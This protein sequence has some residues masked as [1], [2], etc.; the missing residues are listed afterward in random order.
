MIFTKIMN[1]LYPEVEIENKDITGKYSFEFQ[2]KYHVYFINGEDDGKIREQTRKVLDN[3][4]Y[5][6][7]L[8]DDTELSMDGNTNVLLTTGINIKVKD[9]KETDEISD[10]WIKKYKASLCI[11]NYK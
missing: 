9:L 2:K 6:I 4:N 5:K 7:T 3:G 8:E 11:Q 10:E 1:K